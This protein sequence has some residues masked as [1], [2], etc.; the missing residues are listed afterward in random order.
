MKVETEAYIRKAEQ[1]LD[2]AHR[3]LAIAI[4][5]EAGRHAYFAQFHGAQALIYE[6]TG[7][8]AP[9]LP[10]RK[11]ATQSRRPSGSSRR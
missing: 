9:S 10:K 1:A 2:K 4:H 3:I 6:R 11:P 7:T 8:R 5:Q